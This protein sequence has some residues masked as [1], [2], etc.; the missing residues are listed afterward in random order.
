MSSGANDVFAGIRT[1]DL[2]GP[3]AYVEWP[4]ERPDPGGPTFVC[5]HGLGG[6]HLNWMLVGSRLAEHGR[7]LALDLAGFGLTPR[8]GRSSSVAANRR[9]L[10]RFVH[11]MTDGPVILVGNSMGG[12]LSILQAA[13]EPRSAAGLVLTSPALP[14]SRRARPPAALV[15][16][17]FAIYQMPRVGEAFVRA[18]TN[19]LG[20]ERLIEEGFKVVMAD[21]KAVPAEVVEAHVE[22]ARRRADDPDSVPA[23]LQAARSL[24]TLGGRR[25]FVGEVLDRVKVPVL[26]VHGRK[27]RLVRVQLARAAARNRDTW[28]VEELDGVGHAAQ[29]EAPD[30]WTDAVTRWL[31]RTGLDANAAE[32]SA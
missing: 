28:E 23:F 6:S 24:L 15:V 14:W 8:D 10:S 3:V 16:A 12:A 31:E 20:P 7:V 1:V 21:P 29:L 32:A 11:E 25:P 30:R 2:D 5:V 4:S 18:R 22:L 19:R 17:T 26:V 13:Y 9:L 27:D